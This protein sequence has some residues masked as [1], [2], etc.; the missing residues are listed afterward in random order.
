MEQNRCGAS[1]FGARDWKGHGCG[2][3]FCE[4][5]ESAL[6][7]SGCTHSNCKRPEKAKQLKEQRDKLR[8][9]FTEF[10]AHYLEKKT[11]IKL[12]EAVAKAL[13]RGMLDE[14]SGQ[15]LPMVTDLYIKCRQA[16]AYAVVAMAF[17]D[18][19]LGGG[20]PEDDA[21]LASRQLRREGLRL[22]CATV[23]RILE[24]L[25]QPLAVCLRTRLLDNITSVCKEGGRKMMK[26]MKMMK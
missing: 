1:S 25:R 23:D 21:I 20:P 15:L 11:R 16:R 22:R 24:S 14:L 8:P 17:E 9:L 13:E 12:K 10:Q 26:V 19:A 7:D 4:V 3:D 5:C 2:L 6:R 18:N